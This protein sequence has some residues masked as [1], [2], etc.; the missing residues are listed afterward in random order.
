VLVTGS[1]VLRFARVSLTATVWTSAL[2]FGVYILAFYAL[3]VVRGDMEAWNEVLPRLYEPNTPV[4]TSGIALHFATG[5]VVLVLGAIQLLRSVRDAWPA[6]H[7]WIGRVYVVCA[8]AAGLGGLT[9]IAAKG[10]IGGTVMDLGFG[11]YGVLTVLAAVQT[12]R[13][14]R[15]RDLERHR[16][17]AIRLF[18]LAIG[19]WLYRMEYGFWMLLTGGLGHAE[20]FSGPF[21]QVM[22]FFF[23]VPNLLVAEVFIRSRGT[24]GSPA[25]RLGAAGAMSLATV[26]LLV[27]TY[28]FTRY[29]WGPAIV[30]A[31]G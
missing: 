10:T 22:A 18:A 12:F 15:A 24:L 7:R 3:A 23:Y 5:G 26:F 25:L 16:A 28:Y 8:L 21:D 31:F 17:W 1:G 27:G 2:L 14:A 20:G 13:Y 29:Y 6:L 19:S 9:F 30:R 11:L 4:A